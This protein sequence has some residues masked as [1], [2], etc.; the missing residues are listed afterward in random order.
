MF[1]SSVRD[2]STIR[3]IAAAPG[4]NNVSDQVQAELTKS[5]GSAEQ[6]AQRYPKYTDQIVAAARQSF[7]DGD[8]WAYTAGMVAIVLG[9]L[10]VFF[11]F[12]RFEAEK[13]MLARFHAEDSESPAAGPG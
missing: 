1:W 11:L 3:A 12:P 7:L 13:E 8:D 4:G 5:F 2:A 6:L 9:A 10:L